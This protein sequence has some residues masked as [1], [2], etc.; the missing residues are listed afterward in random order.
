[1]NERYQA[2]VFATA[3]VISVAALYGYIQ[4]TIARPVG[5]LE[6]VVASLVIEGPGW[7]IRYT[8][9]TVQNATAFAILREANLTLRFDLQWIPYASPPGNFVTSINGTSNGQLN[10]RAWLYWVDGAFGSV[11]SDRAPLRSGDVVLW[12]FSQYPGA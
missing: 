10:G 4:S 3:L 9:A 1:V 6:T 7:T 12:Q 5:D 11:A 8:N 2:L